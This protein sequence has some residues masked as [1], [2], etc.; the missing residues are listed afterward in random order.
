MNTDARRWIERLQLAAHPEGG[1]YREIYHS[2]RYL[3]DPA[4]VE[5]HGG[6][7][8][9]ATSIYFLLPEGEVSR[10]HRLRSDELWY[11]HY[12]R[13]LVVHLFH[14]GGRYEARELGLPDA[15]GREPQ[16]LVPAGTIF[17]AELIP[18]DDPG[19][20]L[21]GCMVTPGFDFQDFEL[22]SREAVAPLFPDYEDVIARL[23]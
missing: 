14:P 10:L 9:S 20:A 5:A 19:F 12:G 4:T 23:T 15:P 3:S 2:P 6:A 17:G 8:R 11:F 21:V 1:Y 13:P 16:V 18:G 7:R 22:L